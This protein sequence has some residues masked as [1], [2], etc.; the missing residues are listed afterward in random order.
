M[1][2]MSGS[3]P[4]I[5][6]IYDAK[7]TMKDCRQRLQGETA[8]RDCLCFQAP[9]GGI[10]PATAKHILLQWSR[11]GEDAKHIWLPKAAQNT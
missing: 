1:M 4:G 11:E 10:E 2:L 5:R 8:E 3:R 6:H 9:E 7:E